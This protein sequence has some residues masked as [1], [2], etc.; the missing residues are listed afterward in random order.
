MKK[1][2][3][4]SNNLTN[5]G[6]AERYCIYLA[7]GLE[8]AGFHP[9][10]A[11]MEECIIENESKYNGLTLNNTT[12]IKIPTYPKV[13]PR[14]VN[15]LYQDIFT[16]KFLRKINAD[17][18]INVSSYSNISGTGQKNIYIV[19]FPQR[20][21]PPVE[22]NIRTK[23]IKGMH[24]LRKGLHRNKDFFETYDLILANSHFTKSYIN[25]RWGVISEVLEPPCLFPSTTEKSSRR[26]AILNVGRFEVIKK[27]IPHKSQHELINAFRNFKD[28][29]CNGY[30][31]WLAGTAKGEGFS[32]LK[33]LEDLTEGLPV[34]F[35]PNASFSQLQSL[36]KNARFYWHAQG[37]NADIDNY[38]ETQ[39]HFGMTTV[40]AMGYGLIP[41]V[42]NT[43]G[44]HEVTQNISPLLQWSTL[45][46]L[47]D[48]TIR[49]SKLPS[50]S[51]RQLR[52]QV[53]K[54]AHTYDPEHFE[55]K[56]YHF[57]QRLEP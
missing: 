27:N 37:F 41:C 2:L 18:F 5:R 23:Y 45:D 6:G 57:I 56:L 22:G 16:E 19:H 36:Y 3:I 15:N 21:L 46:E 55:E 34:K 49:L 32:Y 24:L 31:L 17:L 51:L 25:E 50:S 30:E 26:N 13:G 12:H 29:D 38:P 44:P 20:I 9:I 11:T 14:A 40:E 7:K 42:I 1:A 8:N 47:V 4:L 52:E 39:E 28:I 33:H 43:A 35:F 10:I 53:Q 48:N 54:R